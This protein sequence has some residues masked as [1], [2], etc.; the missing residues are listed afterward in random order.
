MSRRRR[1]SVSKSERRENNRRSSKRTRTRKKIKEEILKAFLLDVSRLRKGPALYGNLQRTVHDAL[2]FLKRIGE[3]VPDLHSNPSGRGLRG[4]GATE[5]S[6][7][8]NQD[9]NSVARE[10]KRDERSAKEHGPYTPCNDEFWVL[11][12]QTLCGAADE[13]STDDEGQWLV[14]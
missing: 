11:D 1:G 13:Y 5:L 10:A 9:L 2:D 14:I 7:F 8:M 4:D 12:P 6:Q 3:S